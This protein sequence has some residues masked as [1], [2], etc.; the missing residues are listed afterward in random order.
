M[1]QQAVDVAQENYDRS[2]AQ[3]AKTAAAMKEVEKKLEKAQGS[4]CTVGKSQKFSRVTRGF[5]YVLNV[6]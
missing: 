3:Q 2:V 1:A 5:I 4:R 6:Y